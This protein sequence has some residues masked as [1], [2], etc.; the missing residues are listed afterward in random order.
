MK[1]GHNSKN[2]IVVDT[3]DRT[4]ARPDREQEPDREFN[5]ERQREPIDQQSLFCIEERPGYQRAVILE[6]P[7]RVQ[8]YERAGWVA[9]TSESADKSDDHGRATSRLDSVMRIVMNF[10]PDA[11][12]HTGVVMEILLEYWNEDLRNFHEALDRKE[13]SFNPEKFQQ[14]G[15]ENSYGSMKRTRKQIR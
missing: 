8:R 3:G 14:E 5:R 15:F 6:Y 4:F 2:S 9:V 10:R 11:P 12:V 7:G 1:R 13:E